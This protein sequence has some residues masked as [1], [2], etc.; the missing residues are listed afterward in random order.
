MS[1]KSSQ[2]I[3]WNANSLSHKL[4]ELAHLLEETSAAVCLI[5]ETHLTPART[6]RIPNF[7]IY[8]ADRTNCRVPSGGVALAVRYTISHQP[9]LLPPL[10]NIEAVGIEITTGS[11]PLRLI[12]VY[13]SPTKK[14]LPSDLEALILLSNIPTIIAGDLNSKHPSWNSKVANTKGRILLAHSRSNSYSVAG[15]VEPTHF[16]SRSKGLK[17]DVLD[18]ALLVNMRHSIQLETLYALSSDH[19][20]VLIDYGDEMVAAPAQERF[21]L[22]RANWEKFR[23]HLDAHPDNT[24]ISTTSD[25]DQAVLALTTNIQAAAAAAIPLTKTRRSDLY[26]LSPGL[27][28]AVQLKNRA[29]RDWQKLRT[30]DLKTRYNKLTVKLREELQIAR[31]D[32]WDDAVSKLTTKDLSIWRMSRALQRKKQP[33]PPLQGKHFLACSNID[34]AHVYAD[35]LEEQFTNDDD[36]PINHE[37]NFQVDQIRMTYGNA[38]QPPNCTL[39]EVGALVEKLKDK[40]APG[41]DGIQIKMIKMLPS[42]AASRVVMIFNACFKLRYFPVAW[43]EAKIILIPKAGK[44]LRLPENHRPISLLNTLGKLLERLILNGLLSHIKENNVYLP[45]QFGFRAEHATTHQLLRVANKINHGFNINN[46][47]GIV[48][49]DVAKAFD[50]V[51]HNGI[52][53]KLNA[54]KFPISQVEMIDSYLRDREF[55]VNVN[56]TLSSKRNIKSGVPQGSVLGPV[57]FNL[58]TNDIPADS[59]K[60]SIALYADDAAVISS[61]WSSEEVGKNLQIALDTLHEWYSKWKIT[62]NPSKTTATLFTRRPKKHPEPLLVLNNNTIQF[63]KSS[64]YLGVIL[65]KKLNWIEQVKS[66]KSKANQKF[67][68]LFPLFNSKSMRIDTKLLLYKTIIRPVITYASPIWANSVHQKHIHFLQVFQNRVLRKIFHAPMNT[69]IV[70]LHN[71]SQLPYLSEVFIDLTSNFLDSIEASHNPLISEQLTFIPNP[72][73]KYDRIIHLEL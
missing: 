35:S 10:Q 66:V 6:P 4:I 30:P 20:P 70:T 40:K 59:H 1:N 3:S 48:F 23:S 64:K 8:R 31:A 49:L 17:G 54:L 27:K 71:Q 14:L 42:Q 52:V 37:V 58:Y 63:T 7:S 51:W 2:F 46:A 60:T 50:K 26:D 67:S 15:P 43:K 22:K 53:Y 13:L 29:R 19:N 41:P 56:G 62:I 16:S 11:G 9:I 5:Q 68:A 21:N 39:D 72:F 44:N 33:N 73:D 55:R 36:S 34:K 47:T 32:K 57:L 61:S 38:D 24:E 28:K 65:D 69:R 18:I 45:E 25:I 12:S